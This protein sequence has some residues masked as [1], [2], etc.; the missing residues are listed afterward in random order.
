MHDGDDENKHMTQNFVIYGT[1]PDPD[2]FT[3]IMDFWRED[4]V[5]YNRLC[6][7]ADLRQAMPGAGACTIMDNQH[8]TDESTCLTATDVQA[9]RAVDDTMVALT[10][11]AGCKDDSGPLWISIQL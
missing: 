6:L 9:G 8:P 10:R 1:G 7:L 4:A 3:V 11:G 2:N 5:F